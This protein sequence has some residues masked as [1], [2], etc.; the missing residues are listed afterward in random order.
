MN[1]IDF[2][3]KLSEAM[4]EELATPYYI[5]VKNDKENWMLRLGLLKEA[6]GLKPVSKLGLIKPWILGVSNFK[7]HIYPVVDLKRLFSGENLLNNYKSIVTVVSDLSGA[8]IG[9]VWSD[10]IGLFNERD[11]EVID[12]ARAK[13]GQDGLEWLSDKAKAYVETGFRDHQ[14]LAWSV[15]DLQKLLNSEDI[16]NIQG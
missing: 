13:A 10:V 14:G 1:L 4:S 5:A 2:Q 12:S 7:G 9:I 6:S 3:A 8:S 15:L 11:L 16:M